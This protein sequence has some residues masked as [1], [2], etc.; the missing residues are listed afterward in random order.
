MVKCYNRSIFGTLRFKEIERNVALLYKICFY[1]G[2]TESLRIVI[3]ETRYYVYN[4][5]LIFPSLCLCKKAVG[6]VFVGASLMAQ[7]NAFTAASELVNGKPVSLSLFFRN[8]KKQ[9]C[10]RS[11]LYDEWVI[12]STFEIFKYA[13]VTLA[14]WAGRY[15]FQDAFHDLFLTL[16]ASKC[17]IPICSHCRLVFKR[18]NFRF[19]S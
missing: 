19:D 2:H 5:F 17:Y 16:W 7:W 9:L 18:Q 14:E 8:K 11:G 13:F 1:L 3:S 4:I 6:S 10:A 15:H 12:S